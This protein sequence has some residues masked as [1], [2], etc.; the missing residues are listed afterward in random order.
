MPISAAQASKFYEQVVR[1]GSVFTFELQ[2][3]FSCFRSAT[4]KLFHSGRADAESKRFRIPCRS[5]LNTPFTVAVHGVLRA[6][7]PVVR[8]A[9]YSHRRQLER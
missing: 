9:A 8:A 1:D 6:D 3:A 5:M 4:F 7:P 2:R